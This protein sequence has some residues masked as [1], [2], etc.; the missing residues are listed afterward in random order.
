LHTEPAPP[1]VAGQ[2]Q[3]VCLVGRHYPQWNGGRWGASAG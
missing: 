2:R 1:P 3:E